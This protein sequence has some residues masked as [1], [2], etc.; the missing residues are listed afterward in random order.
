MLSVVRVKPVS[1]PEAERAME[2][3]PGFYPGKTPPIDLP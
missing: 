1:R 3:S 2:F